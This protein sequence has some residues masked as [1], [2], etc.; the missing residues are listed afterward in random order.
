MKLEAEGQRAIVD[1]Q[2]GEIESAVL[3]LSPPDRT[4]LILSR[5]AMS[6]IQAAIVDSNHLALEYQDGSAERH[7]R[8]ARN[9]STGEV[10]EIL[11]AY[12]RGEDSWRNE[13]EWRRI[14]VSGRGDAWD[15]LKPVLLIAAVI[16]AID[17]VIA[18][19]QSRV[20]AIFG[21]E[22]MDV[23]SIACVAM[24]VSGI[25][26]LRRFR[27][28]SPMERSRSISLVGAGAFIV[29]I[30]VIEHLTTHWGRIR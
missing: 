17:S 8:S 21:W 26:D 20:D 25:I 16:L 5:S 30:N 3:R 2:R 9:F 6:Y 1:P 28:M 27:T 10:V 23:L 13:S 22:S 4:F 24:M 14:D 19:K 7:F 18:L 15:R 29:T 12:R 11:E